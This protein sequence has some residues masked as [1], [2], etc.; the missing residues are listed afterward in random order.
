MLRKDLTVTI[1]DSDKVEVVKFKTGATDDSVLI[2]PQ[3]PKFSVL[4]SEIREALNMIESFN[5]DNSRNNKKPIELA[6]N[7]AI[8][9]TVNPLNETPNNLTFEYGEDFG[10]L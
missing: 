1:I 5:K 7:P 4:N 10:T 6:L 9:S 8:N 3:V 2:E